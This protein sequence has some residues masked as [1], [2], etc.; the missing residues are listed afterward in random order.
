MLRVTALLGKCSHDLGRV[1]RISINPFLHSPHSPIPV[2]TP[3]QHFTQS[4][5]CSAKEQSEWDA[6]AAMI[7][8]ERIFNKTHKFQSK[9]RKRGQAG[10]RMEEEEGE[11]EEGVKRERKF[12]HWK[13][14]QNR[15]TRR[16]TT[17]VKKGEV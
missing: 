7:K 6:F 5:F 2:L 13:I 1:H 3:N 14:K 10:R 8:G 16:I 17:F 12:S 4:S 11:G 9:Q 15:Y